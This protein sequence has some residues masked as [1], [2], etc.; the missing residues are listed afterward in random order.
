M[1]SVQS[2]GGSRKRLLYQIVGISVFRGRQARLK[3][4]NGNLEDAA[5]NQLSAATATNVAAR[6]ARHTAAR[7]LALLLMRSAAVSHADGAPGAAIQSSNSSCRNAN[8][9][10]SKQRV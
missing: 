6:S 2:G 8:T 10:G 9:T 7:V 1:P 4:V 5:R 3:L